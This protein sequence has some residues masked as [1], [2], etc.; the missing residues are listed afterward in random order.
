MYLRFFA[1]PMWRTSIKFY[2]EKH[3]GIRSQNDFNGGRRKTI[4]E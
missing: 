4:T 3:H 1:V 2:I